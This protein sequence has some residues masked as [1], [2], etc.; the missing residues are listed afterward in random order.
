MKSQSP[1]PDPAMDPV[2]SF[3]ERARSAHV[4]G[5]DVYQLTT[6]IAHAADGRLH[7][8]QPLW[9]S[10][11]FRR[12]P[13][14]RRFVIP[15]G[16]RSI[17]EH[18]QA[19]R[20]THEELSTLDQH[21]ILGPALQSAP[22]RAV[23]EA[24]A[25][26]DGFV[27]DIDAL[28]EGTPAFAGP[29]LSA[30][31]E[32]IVIDGVPL[33]A[34]TPLIQ[35]S[36]SMVQ[37][38]LIET[39]WLSRLNHL[40]MVASKAAR[41]VCAARADGRERPVIEFGQRRTHPAAAVDAAYAAYLA[42]C[43][44]T[45]NLLATH[46]YGVPSVGTMDHFAVQAAERIGVP[47]YETERAFFQRFYELFPHASTLLVDTYDTWRGIRGAVGAT[48]GRCLG[49]RLDS[50]VTPENVRK[51]RE[52]LQSLGAPQVSIFVSDG[53]DE[54]RVRELAQAGAD[55]FG[56]GE[57]ITCSP[58]AATGIGAVGKLVQ[59]GHGKRTM[60]V[61]RGSG[62]ATLPGRLQAYRFDDHD[63]VCGA[64][65]PPPPGGR[66]LLVPLWR[67]RELVAPLPSLDA[68]R[69]SVQAQLQALPAAFTD[70]V[71]DG[72]GSDGSPPPTWPI[73]LSDALLAQV[74]E[75]IHAAAHA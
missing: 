21:P 37:A 62:K 14:H 38:K 25:A 36:T 26:V 10:F 19:L 72:Q 35:V 51:A 52:L 41:I 28:P 42:G 55:G 48:A 74:R 18:C 57:N 75:L 69:T 13:R 22:G 16:L 53:L 47:V 2:L 24:L 1:P 50:D 15:C 11:F 63:H 23:R 54:Y 32:P 34:Y 60:K 3:A 39:P 6:L 65:E 43:R 9:M 40:S 12:M 30:S 56:V 44:A 33:I 8:S 49:V 59:N 73:V 61:A 58:D 27:G 70:I 64:D 46:R 71:R 20:L 17:V 4:F 7:S 67:G 66:P 29:A 5:L 68:S 31:R 45:S